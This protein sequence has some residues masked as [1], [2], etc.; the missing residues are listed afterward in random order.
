GGPGARPALYPGRAAARPGAFGPGRA[1][2]SYRHAADQARSLGSGDLFAA[3]AL[4][5]AHRPVASGTGD[6]EVVELLEEALERLPPGYEALRI[7]LLS[8]LAG[9][10]RYGG[11][12][13]A[14]SVADASV[15]AAR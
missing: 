15:A 1:R 9:E 10:L 4:G 3:A 6:S 13:R 12:S 7:R 11:Q 14:E 8:R 2:V 5:F